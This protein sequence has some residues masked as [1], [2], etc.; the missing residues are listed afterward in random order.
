MDRLFA[1]FSSFKVLNILKEKTYCPMIKHYVYMPN[2]L[3]M[4]DVGLWKIGQF[5]RDVKIC[6]DSSRKSSAVLMTAY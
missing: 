3:G 1:I 6:L 5:K 4:Q 2:E